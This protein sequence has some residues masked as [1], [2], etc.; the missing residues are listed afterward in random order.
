[1]KEKISTIKKE[2]KK[3][4][5]IIIMN[6]NNKKED[7]KEDISHP[8]EINIDAIPNNISKISKITPIKRNGKNI[9]DINKKNENEKMGNNTKKQLIEIFD[10][11]NKENKNENNDNLTIFNNNDISNPPQ[12]LVVCYTNHALDSFIEDILKYTDDVVRIGGRCKNEKVKQKALN[13]S[14]KFSNRNYRGIVKELE[15]IGEDMKDITSLIDIRRRVDVWD[16][17]TYFKE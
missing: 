8:L 16:V 10:N 5:N 6:Y 15:E 11:L 1:M 9:S 4:N 13:N 14:A 3:N 7:K 2:K 17:K 12:I